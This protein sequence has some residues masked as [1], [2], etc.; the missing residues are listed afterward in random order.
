M[1]SSGSQAFD[2]F[3]ADVLYEELRKLAAHRLANEL[4]GQTL[5]ATCL[6]HEVYLR[7]F[8]PQ[9]SDRW[10]KEANFFASAAGNLRVVG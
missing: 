7:L 5:D 3:E 10:V 6:V 1:N 9:K 2:P 4:P 8:A